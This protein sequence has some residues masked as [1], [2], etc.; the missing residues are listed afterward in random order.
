MRVRR[1]PSVDFSWYP[2][3]PF[4]GCRLN[5]QLWLKKGKILGLSIG[6][7]EYILFF[8]CSPAF[9]LT[10]FIITSHFFFLLVL[11]TYAVPLLMQ[12]LQCVA[13][14][15]ERR[16]VCL[17]SPTALTLQNRARQSL[18]SKKVTFKKLRAF[19]SLMRQLIFF[20]AVQL[21]VCS[22]HFNLSMYYL[23]H[24]VVWYL[25]FAGVL[26]FSKNNA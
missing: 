22:W 7:I 5:G 17:S 18:A 14:Q 13:W 9:A 21:G 11:Q 19:Y 6:G 10:Y 2:P 4:S 12:K 3:N 16:S 26:F 8:L 25:L 1:G 23:C 20:L 15:K 24:K